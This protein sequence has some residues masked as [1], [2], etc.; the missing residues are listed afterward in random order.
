MSLHHEISFENEICAHLAASGWIYVEG[1]YK[2]YN[3]ERALFQSDVID[4]RLG[5]V[6]SGL[7]TRNARRRSQIV[8]IVDMT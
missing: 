6:V 3:R 8:I 7:V 4:W 2:L 5:T 1:D